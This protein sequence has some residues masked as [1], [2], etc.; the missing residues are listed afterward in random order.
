MVDP[1]KLYSALQ[2]LDIKDVDVAL[3]MVVFVISVKVGDCSMREEKE[4]GSRFG[5]LGVF[6]T[7]LWY[8]L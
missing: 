6:H 5:V 4:I 8:W 3:D 2:L 1:P 7:F